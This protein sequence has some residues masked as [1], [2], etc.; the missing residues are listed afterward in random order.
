MG[1]GPR[2]APAWTARA[3]GVHRIA[4]AGQPGLERGRVRGRIVR[5]RPGQDDGSF[6]NDV[7]PFPLFP[8]VRMLWLRLAALRLGDFALKGLSYP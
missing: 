1:P 6:G 3:I 4:A 5:R 8:P 7:S 2:R